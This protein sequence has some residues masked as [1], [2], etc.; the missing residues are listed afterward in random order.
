MDS[1]EPKWPMWAY[2]VSLNITTRR[3]GGACHVAVSGRTRVTPAVDLR[4][5]DKGD[6]EFGVFLCTATKG[7]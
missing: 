5:F 6:R 4:C 2:R 7:A 1:G 3:L